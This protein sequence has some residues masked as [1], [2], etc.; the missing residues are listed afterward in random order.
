MTDLGTIFGVKESRAF[1]IN[2]LGQIVGWSDFDIAGWRH[3]V[4]WNAYTQ[5][6]L[7]GE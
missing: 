4:L 1:A 7:R 3:A 6:S 2:N 5:L